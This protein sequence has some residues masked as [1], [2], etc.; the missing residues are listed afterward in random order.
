MKRSKRSRAT[1]FTAKARE[2]I[3]ERD[4][5][6][7]IFCAMGYR[8]DEAP[9]YEQGI[10]E[11]MHYIPKSQGGRGIEQNGALGCKAHHTMFDNGKYRHEMGEIF[12][13]YLSDH[14]YAWSRAD[15]IYD[16]WRGFKID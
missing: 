1:E 16:K 12:G 7:C 3:Y 2:A 5:R 15:L 14:Y 13:K 10:I 6:Q 9:L 11:C 4:G 8:M